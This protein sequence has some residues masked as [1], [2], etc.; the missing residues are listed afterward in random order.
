MTVAGDRLVSRARVLDAAACAAVAARVHA[1]RAHWV[2]R[3]DC[4]F[5][6]L[7][8]ALYLDRP[9]DETRARFDL[10]AAEPARYAALAERLNP[11]LS[12][13]FGALH[14]LLADAL[15]DLLGAA[16]R[17]APAR[18]LPGFHIFESHPRY[19]RQA[20]HVPH[21]DRQY[22][23]IEWPD[24]A[25]IDFSTAISVTL[26]LRLPAR[27]GGL[28]VWDLNLH[29]VQALG[30][31]AA[32]ERARVAPARLHRYAVG[33]LVCHRGH[34]LHQIQPWPARAGEQRLTLQAHGLWFDGAWQ[35][36]W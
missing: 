18:A 36:Y 34:L 23:C 8:A 15:A 12:T 19:A 26:P 11:L 3:D 7:G 14:R 6:T 9:T 28:R 1:L 31:Q 35:L 25:A 16:V 5:H 10:P 33:E 2:A 32:R 22:E 21:F 4:A 24:G 13:H 20:A 27:G 30:P 29:E 17:F